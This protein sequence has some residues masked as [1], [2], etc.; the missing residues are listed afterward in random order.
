MPTL[1]KIITKFYH[2]SFVFIRPMT[3]GVRIILLDEAKQQV[4]LVRHTYAPGWHFPGGGVDAGETMVHAAIRELWEEC[5]IKPDSTLVLQSTHFNQ[6]INNRD[7]VMVYS[8][9]A[10]AQ[11]LGFKPSKE[12][13]EARFFPLDTLPEEITPSTRRRL[14]EMAGEVEPAPYW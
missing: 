12:I 11:T 7:H 14:A 10:E 5:A 1:S 4:L 6:K 8:A 9:T 13:A 2:M 3:L